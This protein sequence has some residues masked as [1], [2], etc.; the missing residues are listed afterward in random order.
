ME[1]LPHGFQVMAIMQDRIPALAATIARMQSADSIQAAE[2][3][4]KAAGGMG[5][6]SQTTGGAVAVVRARGFVVQHGSPYD[7]FFGLLSVDSLANSMRSLA[8]D[9]NVSTVILDWDSPGG[10]SSGV[11]EL[12]DAIYAM[13]GTKRVVSVVNTLMASAG[14]WIGSAASEIVAMPSSYTGSIGTYIAHVDMSA[15]YAAAGIKVTLIT[16][17]KYKA[18]WD[19]SQPL[20]DEAKAF[21]QKAVDDNYAKFVGNVARNR[22]VKISEVLANYGQGRV[23]SADDAVKSGM[24]DRIGTLDETVSREVAALAKKRSIGMTAEHARRKLALLNLT[25]HY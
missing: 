13:R 18:E 22:G 12:S 2:T 5:G 21:T 11:E 23:F 9:P 6:G 15:V 7:D 8:S 3:A 19:D 20:S 1:K 17:G 4:M 24:A 14:Y 10:Y 25:R 16:A